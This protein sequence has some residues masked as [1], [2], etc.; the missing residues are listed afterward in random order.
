[1]HGHMVLEREPLISVA[2]QSR[3]PAEARTRVKTV[4]IDVTPDSSE[5]CFAT[6]APCLTASRGAPRYLRTRRRGRVAEGGGLLNRYTLQRRIEGSNPSVS[7]ILKAEAF[8]KYLQG[9]LWACFRAQEALVRA[10][11]AQTSAGP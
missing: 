4:G 2:A 9:Q 1:M 7:A 8:K 5:M 11:R 3:V 10:V 6:A